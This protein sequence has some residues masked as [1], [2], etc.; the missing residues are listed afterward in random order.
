MAEKVWGF[1][2]TLFFGWLV[3]VLLVLI[4]VCAATV[5]G[6]V[7]ALN[8]KTSGFNGNDPNNIRQY[9]LVGDMSQNDRQ[10]KATA[11]KTSGMTGTRDIPVFFQD[12][13]Y[14]MSL[15]KTGLSNSREGLTDPE[16]GKKFKLN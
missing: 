7:G 13:D 2:S 16:E 5:A 11:S 1:D 3:V 8:H 10:A 9:Q 12:Y 4:L 6:F 15:S 14:D